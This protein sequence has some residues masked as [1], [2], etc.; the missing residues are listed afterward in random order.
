MI[1]S[2]YKYAG[3]VEHALRNPVT[4]RDD[5]HLAAFGFHLR[6]QRRLLLGRPLPTPFNLRNDLHVRQAR[7]PLEQ[8]KTTPTGANLGNGS[9]HFYT[10][11]AGR[12]RH[13]YRGSTIST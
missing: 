13:T 4:P 6:Q 3:I 8:Q 9:Q 2:A 11:M 7:L 5:R 1:A 10:P 12:L